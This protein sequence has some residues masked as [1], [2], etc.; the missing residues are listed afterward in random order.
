[1]LQQTLNRYHNRAIETQEVIEELI[2]VA[3]EIRQAIGRG[4]DLG[5]NNDELAFY[6]ALADNDSARIV[7][8]DDKL[9]LIA[10]ELVKTV[11]QSVTIDWH[12]REQARSSIRVIIKRILR[13]HGYPPDLTTDAA[14]LVLQQA[15]ALCEEWV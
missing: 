10:T 2:R 12:L 7:M 9:K 15:E 14:Q 13:K 11:R 6:D 4:E 1:M 5:L 3:T 8:G